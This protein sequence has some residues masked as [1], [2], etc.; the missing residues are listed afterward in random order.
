MREWI[1][2]GALYLLALVL[3][4]QL[5]GLRA[6]A[7]AFRRWGRASGDVRSGWVSPSSG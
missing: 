6:A 2:I 1:L 3:F 7:G 5:G 4:G